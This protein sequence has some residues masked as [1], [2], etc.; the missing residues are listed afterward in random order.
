M[1]T[2]R[3]LFLLGLVGGGL[4]V[5]GAQKADAQE[6][7]P[8]HAVG[9][10]PMTA[11]ADEAKVQVRR[12][13][14]TQTD[15]DAVGMLEK[16]DLELALFYYQYRQKGAEGVQAL[17][18]ESQLSAAAT[19]DSRRPREHRWRHP[20]SSDGETVM[21]EAVATAPGP[22][23]DDLRRLGLTHGA[24]VGTLV[25]GRL[26][27]EALGAAAQLSALRS[28]TA[29]HARLRAGRV[30]SEADTSHGS[31]RVRDERR[32]DGQGQKVCVLSDSYNQAS[33]LPISA[34]DDVKSGDLPGPDNPEGRTTPVDVLEDFEGGSD[35]GRAML[36]LIHD[37][38]PA[39]ELG[40]HTAFNGLPAF[41]EAIPRLAEEGDCTVIVDDIGYANEPFYQDGP[42][43][44]AVDSVV[45][46]YEVP[47]FSA[48]GNDG[49]NAYAA[50]FRNSGEAGAIDGDS[51]R[52]NFAPGGTD[53]AQ[54][55]TVQN[56]GSFRI[57]TFQWT[58]PSSIVEGSEGTET[59]LD[60]AI[61]DGEGTVV[62]QSARNNIQ[63]GVPVEGPLQYQN[64]TGS[65]VTLDLVIEKAGGPDP[66]SVKYIYSGRGYTIEDDYGDAQHPTIYG[67]S[68]AEGAMAVAAA[69]FFNTAA[70][71]ENVATAVLGP[72]SSKGGVSILFDQSGTRLA[73]PERR[74]K[75]EITGAEGIDNTFFGADLRTD[76]A[77][78]DPHPNFFG[79]SAAAPNVA[80]IAAL[81]RQARPELGPRGVY[82]RLA[83]TALDVT[84]RQ[85]QSGEFESVAE[86]RDPW[87]GHGFVDA[88]E[89]VPP[90]DVFDLQVAE[91]SADG[92]T[93]E[94]SWSVRE[95]A[96]IQRYDVD[97]RYFNVGNEDAYEDLAAP[98]ASPVSFDNP[99]LGVY[100]Y[101][102]QWT[103][104]DG[105]TGERTVR[106]TLGIRA[107]AVDGKR[108]D[109]DGR[110][111]VEVVWAGQ[112][113]AR[114][115]N[116]EYRLERKTGTE[117]PFTPVRTVSATSAS[118]KAPDDTIRVSAERQPPGTY[119]YR[120][121]AQDDNAN[122]ITS[123]SKTI[124]IPFDDAVAIGPYPN[125]TQAAATID[126]TA[127][128]NQ[129]VDVEVYNP[130]GQRIYSARDALRAQAARSLTLPADRWG[131][132]FYLVRLRGETFT[133]TRK[134]VVRK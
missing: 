31:V 28:M 103:R 91:T 42:V 95:G 46:A 70:Y 20:V 72:F 9:R 4:V 85:T 113:G 33:G 129:R 41:A 34:S 84:E 25:S 111:L 94:L 11:V 43:S 107:F 37:I 13:G 121:Q 125:P 36:Q 54:R 39:A 10:V 18:S 29:S 127:E 52:H 118:M 126:L 59:D 24:A 62:T 68:G 45:S 92:R 1:S 55:I 102:V 86:G 2:V 130:L 50:A 22:L 112:P 117:G 27:V 89:A 99:G 56:G 101:R 133:K 30:G 71:N 110:Q 58:A 69:P 5:T 114:T 19:S 76:L 48:A 3:V 123:A 73:R 116:F 108:M 12:A 128:K 66:D 104:A 134:L 17:R 53:T 106:D 98:S 35:E 67:H 109:E 119:T 96:D 74:M 7:L 97:R 81:I 65:A 51:E 8:S 44:T 60:V 57:F 21:I 115:A 93:L 32:I 6:L 120:V 100:T 77:D 63:S 75:P 105:G 47:Y 124:T 78:P 26:P 90:R 64:T 16:I 14:R 131:S 122:T 132:G 38:A 83:S 49:Q 88:Q 82:D 61:V 79:T 87:S 40:F 15:K 80:A 23:L